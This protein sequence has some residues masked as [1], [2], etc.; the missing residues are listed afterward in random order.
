M[1]YEC[2]TIITNEHSRAFVVMIMGE[3]ANLGLA[4]EVVLGTL[5]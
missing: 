3:W 2:L 5:T 1:R 4:Y